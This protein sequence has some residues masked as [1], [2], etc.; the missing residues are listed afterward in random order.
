MTTP[1]FS[2][3]RQGENRVTATFLSVLQRLSHPNA[4]RILR[5]LLDEDSFSLVSFQNQVRTKHSVPDAVIRGATVWVETKTTRNA[6]RRCQIEDHLES[7]SNDQ[8]LLVLTPDDSKP[9]ALGEVEDPGNILAWSNFST[10]H[11]V[12]KNILAD[13]EEPP[14]EREAFLLNELILMLRYDGLLSRPS[15]VAVVAA[16]SAWYMYKTL[17]VYRCARSL[18]LRT[19]IEY[20]AFYSQGEI[21]PIV[22]KV[23]AIVD[24]LNLTDE[25]S[26][27]LIESA[28]TKELALDLRQRIHEGS[29]ELGWF[30]GEFKVV[31]LGELGDGNNTVELNNPIVNDKT[32]ENGKSVAFTYGKPRYF[33]LESL[34]DVAQAAETA[35][36]TEL[37]RQVREH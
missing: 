33:T 25:D 34:R 37:E 13:E 28:A 6:V 5:T 1:L 22:A 11:E 20:M 16:S 2:T 7:V 19:G 9:T 8:K 27:N 24:P 23:K 26:V 12:I 14:S 21:Q 35:K 29:G 17:P 4:D 30:D 36:T 32:S 3:Y 31:F 15:N 18:P 10:L